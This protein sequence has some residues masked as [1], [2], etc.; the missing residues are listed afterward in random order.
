VRASTTIRK[1]GFHLT[2]AAPV[3]LNL[4]TNCPQLRRDCEWREIPSMAQDRQEEF[5]RKSWFKPCPGR[6][7]CHRFPDGGPKG[8]PA[9]RE[10]PGVPRRFH[11]PAAV[12][13]QAGLDQGGMG[14]RRPAKISGG[15]RGEVVFK[16]ERTPEL[17]GRLGPDCHPRNAAVS[18]SYFRQAGV[19]SGR[20]RRRSQS[21]SWS[22]RVAQPCGSRRRGDWGANSATTCGCGR[23]IEGGGTEWGL[24]LHGWCIQIGAFNK[25]HTVL[26]FKT[27]GLL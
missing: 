5:Y 7:A 23:R 4:T 19:P 8:P 12:S 13:A 17:P 27:G 2:N 9:C 20:R 14:T 11:R 16:M 6:G 18:Q 22:G 24:T 25:G 3:C 15:G 1:W 10:R 26:G 21:G